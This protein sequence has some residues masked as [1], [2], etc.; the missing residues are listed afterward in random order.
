MIH[1]L[2]TCAL[3]KLVK[4]EAETT[5]LRA[6]MKNLAPDDAVVT[7][8]LAELE[9]SRALTRNGTPADDVA[10][11]VE[12]ILGTVDVVVVSQAVLRVAIAYRIKR[13]GSLD[14]IHL[15]TAEM[16]GVELQSFVTYDSELA[17]AAKDRGLPVVAPAY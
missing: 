6:W 11:L 8:Q 1:Y 10:E 2:D 16:F 9:L 14:S 12:E 15:A 4:V 3:L 13:L 5:A 7:S 17:D